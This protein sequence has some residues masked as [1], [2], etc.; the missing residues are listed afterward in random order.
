MCACAG[1]TT[2]NDTPVT[3]SRRRTCETISSSVRRSHACDPS[4]CS[5]PRSS[6]MS[7][8]VTGA[9]AAVLASPPT[10]GSRDAEIVGAAPTVLANFAATVPVFVHVINQGPTVEDGVP[11]SQIRA[12]I[13]V[14]N[15]TFN[16][17]RGGTDHEGGP[18]ALNIYT[19]E[20]GG[21]LGWVY[22]LLS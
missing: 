14:L 7:A 5:M 18:D 9:R 13:D 12:Q 15:Q 11:D 4:A 19:T 20:G 16:G 10:R 22:R 6:S 2:R 17:A 3:S 8:S 21:F 1:S